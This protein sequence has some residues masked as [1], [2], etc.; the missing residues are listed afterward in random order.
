MK[1]KKYGQVKKQA[2]VHSENAAVSLYLTLM[3]AVM[4]PLI[5]TMIEGARISAI[6]LRLECA[7][8][9]MA[10]SLLS[11]YNRE[12]LKQYDL[13]LIDTAYD[14]G[15]GSLDHLLAHLEEYLSYNLQP[16]KGTY[17][18]TDRDLLGLTL[19][20]AEIVGVSRATDE[21]GKVFEYLVISAMLEKYGLA[22][23][24]DVQDMIA[25]STTQQL[26]E[27]DIE[28]DCA[29]SQGAVD[30]IEVPQPEPVYDEAGNE[31][32][33]DWHPPAKDDPAGN[34][35]SVSSGGILSLVCK[36]PVS[37]ISFAA[38]WGVDQR[39]L[40][41]GDGCPEDWEDR[42]TL[43]E[44]LL[45]N[46]FVMEKCGCYTE[47]KENS[48]LQYEIEYIA[49]GHD[50]DAE[51]LKAV[52]HR[53]LLFRGG[54]NGVHYA[55][56]PVLQSE[57]KAMAAGLS[58]VCFMP[59]C[60]PLFEAVIAAAWIYAESL[61][62]VRILFSGGR[63]PLIKEHSDWNLSLGS[64]LSMGI[65]MGISTGMDAADGAI[66]SGHGLNYKDHLRL[67]LYLT[68]AQQ[69][70]NRCMNV[71]EMDIRKIPGY[72]QFRLD[73]CVA[74]AAVQLV[75]RSS[76]GYTFLMERRFRYA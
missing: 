61:A 25:T 36:A 28:A 18:F 23:V 46:E 26:Y 51:N 32:E 7:A 10:D 21:E 49:M 22:Y 9:L 20:S 3:L 67:L 11:E 48:Y 56:D 63:I 73:D 2:G 1:R 72:E 45:F 37:Q 6:K 27:S 19:D 59:E 4:I 60:E 5:L 50:N 42:N 12:L 34:V 29:S 54:A 33:S 31:I 16:S 71:V 69:K 75:F 24:A 47:A 57:A 38:E 17:L 55:A 35:R 39:S 30:A 62:D 66:E 44:Q 15:S 43:A 8:D 65:S 68:P 41:K 13:L 64:A 76:Y 74:G 14:T 70:R 40:V 52:A 53:L 58:F